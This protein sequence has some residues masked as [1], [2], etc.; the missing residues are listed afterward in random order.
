MQDILDT[1]AKFKRENTHH[2]LTHVPKR[3][4]FVVAMVQSK[5]LSTHE[6]LQWV[7]RWRA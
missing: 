2:D 7:R 1:V 5:E 3:L 6:G 4:D